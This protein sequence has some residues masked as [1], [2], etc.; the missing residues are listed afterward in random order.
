[1][2]RL[3]LVLT[4]GMM[5]LAFTGCPGGAGDEIVVIIEDPDVNGTIEPDTSDKP[6]VDKPPTDKPPTDKLPTDTSTTEKRMS[7]SAAVRLLMR[8][9]E[10]ADVKRFKKHVASLSKAVDGI[11]V[12]DGERK[13]AL[14]LFSIKLRTLER[15]ADKLKGD[16]LTPELRIK[17]QAIL[18]ELEDLAHRI[19]GRE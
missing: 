10:R 18:E 13:R 11:K 1:M 2:K 14:N 12:R 15:E 6:P 17:A 4:L 19:E 3:L 5:V 8:D 9:V 16:E 7:L